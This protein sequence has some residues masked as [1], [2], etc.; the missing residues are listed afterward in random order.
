MQTQLNVRGMTCGHCEKRVVAALQAVPG[1]TSASAQ[2]AANR[3][4]VEH[5]GQASTAALVAAVVDAGYEADAASPEA[6]EPGQS[7]AEDGLP[8][9]PPQTQTAELSITGMTC[10]ACV[11]AVE[12][13]LRK[14]PGVSAATVQLLQQR[15][16]IVYDPM[17]VGPRELVA[18]IE[19]AGYEA[20]LPTAQPW[21]ERL[22]SEPAP[23]AP[24]AAVVGSLLTG[25]VLMALG[26]PLMHGGGSHVHGATDPLTRA[27]MALDGSL[28]GLIPQLYALDHG[29]LRWTSAALATAVL[30]GAGRRFFVRALAAARH[31]SADMNTLVALGTGAAWLASWPALLFPAQLEAHNLPLDLWFEAIPWVTGFVLLGQWL[32]DRAK[33]STQAALRKL[34]SLQVDH[35][36]IQANDGTTREVALTEVL[37]GDV[38]VLGAGER[39][40]ADA[41]VVQGTVETDESMLTGESLPV[42]R[43]KGTRVLAGA[44]VVDGAATAR[45][46]AVG[47]DS[48]LAAIARLT[49]DAAAT[50]PSV[51]ASADAVVRW[52]APAVVAVAVLAALGWLWLGPAPALPYAIRAALTV[53]VIAC[54]CALGLAVPAAL[55]V[56]TGR[57]AQLGLLVRSPRA[58]EA[59]HLIDTVLLDKTGTLTTGAFSVTGGEPPPAD[60]QGA[61]AGLWIGAVHPLARALH[62]H[63]AGA[64]AIAPDLGPVQVIAGRGQ[65]ALW[66]GAMLRAGSLRWLR[67]EG[68]TVPDDVV[69]A[70]TTASETGSAVV[71]VA[72]GSQWLG[73]YGLEDTLRPEAP[74]ALHALHQLGMQVVVASGDRPE[75]VEK[76]AR[77]CGVDRWHAGMQPA[78]KLALLTELQAAGRRVCMVGDGSNDAPA[79]SAANL[80]L[81]MGEGTEVA[82]AAADIVLLRMDLRLL[83]AAFALLRA[84]RR[85][86]QGN[87]FWAFAYNAVGLP[88]A[89]G[90]LYP[91]TG[92]LLTPAFASAAMALSSLSVVL[93]A[94]RLRWWQ[95]QLAARH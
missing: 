2:A 71:A 16:Q 28:Q 95:P 69:G 48:T 34:A 59:G 49:A 72:H 75:A 57:A 46:V 41:V 64:A 90:V 79:L 84:T 30:A 25:V 36:R 22:R 54:P 77:A 80:G 40:A 9:P 52:F 45:V 31:K 47:D 13:A 43:G 63:L 3:A 94:L 10:A 58:L 51:Q 37:P 76:V 50:K 21:H 5:N 93:H 6:S 19:K 82:T 73:W 23:E 78:E 60:A 65:Q 86:V 14:T 67:D 61:L 89:A 26:M 8:G 66:R 53:L 39:V 44:Q 38:L 17:Q 56:A 1:V 7:D 42:P 12:R 74:A 27:A 33:H 85:V 92:V 81:A 83:P 24:L 29:L 32:D 68:V 62:R 15:G 18:A 35:A 91:W 70:L 55:A 20:A 87:L 88:L 4:S 11:G